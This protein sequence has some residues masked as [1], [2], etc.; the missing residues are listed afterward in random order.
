[1]LEALERITE[2]AP[3]SDASSRKSSIRYDV[4]NSGRSSIC[5]GS[6]SAS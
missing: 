3:N 1:L 6:E 5:S 4:K 2:R